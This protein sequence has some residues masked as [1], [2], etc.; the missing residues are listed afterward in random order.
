MV[1]AAVA[2]A[3]LFL[4]RPMA[5]DFRIPVRIREWPRIHRLYVEETFVFYILPLGWQFDP[6]LQNIH[7]FDSL[8]LHV[9]FVHKLHLS[10]SSAFIL[11][12]GTLPPSLSPSPCRALVLR[13]EVILHLIWI[14][15]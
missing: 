13:G 7:S 11:E 10:T 3:P 6:L 2:A 9:K 4:L 8:P 14:S 15:N 5:L 12:P 1:A